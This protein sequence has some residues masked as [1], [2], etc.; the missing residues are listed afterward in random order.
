M[1]TCA[2]E[3]DYRTACTWWSDLPDIWT[4]IG[5]KDHLFRFNVLWNGTIIAQPDLNKRTAAWKGQGVQIA[6]IPT[7]NEPFTCLLI[8]TY[9]HSDENSVRQGWNDGVTPVLWSEW[10]LGGVLLRQEIFAHVPG[11]QAVETGDEPLFAW[12]RFSV[13]DVVT[14]LPRDP[15]LGFLL[16]INAPHFGYTMNQRGHTFPVEQSA[17]PRPLELDDR[18][19]LDGDLVRLAVDSRQPGQVQYLPPPEDSRDSFLYVGLRDE[20]GSY[21]D[22]LLPMLPTEREIVDRELAL[23]FDAALAETDRY[24]AVTPPTAATFHTPEPEINRII[25]RNLHFAEIIAERNPA[26]GQYALLTGSLFYAD[27]WATPMAMTCTMFLDTLGYHDAV[28]KYLE[29]FRQEQGTVAAPGDGFL[30]HP[31]YLSSPKTLTSIDWLSDHGAILYAIAEHALLSGDAAFAER[32][33]EV[34]VQACEF[35]HYAR[36]RTDHPGVPGILPPAVATDHGTRIQAVW[37]DGWNYKGLTAAVKL[38]RQLGHQRAEE[39]AREADDYRTA[40]QAAFRAKAATMPIWQDTDG[41]VHQFTPTAIIGD[42]PFETCSGFYLDTG[43]LFP[44]FAGLLP[45][46]DPLMRS[47]VQWFR[48]GPQTKFHR[49]DANCWQVPC[50]QYE[51][52]SCEPAYSWNLFHSW[53]LGDRQHFLTGVYSL[54][55]GSCSRKTSTFCETRGGITGITPALIVMWLARLAVADD[56]LEA[57]TLHLLRLLPLAWLTP[58]HPAVFADLP[59]EYGPVTLRVQPGADGVLRVEY[60]AR[61]RTPPS[62]VWLHIPPLPNLAAV[63]VNGTRVAIQGTDNTVNMLDIAALDG[64]ETARTSV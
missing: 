54:F 11:G 30:L 12:V 61:Y 36:S 22:L 63:E 59:T 41:Q 58:D 6:C 49:F 15:H 55:A 64:R 51:M 5:W 44:V 20:V 25:E 28:A 42:T 10:S 23:G 24:W 7:L 31:G 18:Y 52:S 40:F 27:M 32:Y 56:Q 39:F 62:H 17:Y 47:T 8:P 45:A 19:L 53:Q 35:I 46:D 26:D 33:T 57:D 48:E 60:A 3:P 2:Y 37:N 34:I 16:K 38:L 29:I 14:A 50:L 43:P 1:H 13:R 21:I 4:P 9:V